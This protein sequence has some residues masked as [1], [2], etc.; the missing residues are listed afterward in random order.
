[1]NTPLH[2]LHATPL[3]IGLVL[4]DSL[5]L[6][7]GVPQHVLIL[8][9]W[10]RGKGHQVHFLTTSTVRSDIPNI[11]SLSAGVV[12][13]DK[14]VLKREEVEI[15]RVKP[16]SKA[17]IK[18]LFS[19]VQFD[20]LHVQM[21]YSPLTSGRIVAAAPAHT[22]IFGT[23]HALPWDPT[24]AT[25]ARLQSWFLRKQIR[26]FQQVFAVSS[27]SANFAEQTLRITP[28]VIGNPVRVL[29]FEQAHDQEIARQAT[30][31]FD[32]D[33]P[34]RIFF[35][36]RI[37]ENKG[38]IPLLAAARRLLDITT[39]PFELVIGG[40]GPL[41]D[42]A[43]TYTAQYGLDSVTTYIGYVP[44]DDKADM[45]AQA[46]ITVL[47][48]VAGE[49]YGVSLV[50]ALAASSGVVVAGD[51][52]GYRPMMSGLEENLIDV[53]NTEAFA[54]ILKKYVEDRD[55]RESVRER[56]VA[57]ARSFDVDTIGTR[58]VQ[59]YLN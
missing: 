5:D 47:P 13:R 43:L 59:A 37:V 55:A 26:R 24:S 18:A 57:R 9:R 6:T 7:D 28:E 33:Q 32:E 29:G 3:T 19:E 41:L 50:E 45:L 20:V 38:I 34:V 42:E 2:D 14:R 27:P 17:K 56:Q 46:D 1:M 39:T 31:N 16:A 4:D 23:Y 53:K 11:H 15:P 22:K 12:R 54:R 25:K 48:A 21:P 35:L 52:P 40:K 8:G 36:G 51:N 58:L 10:L 49:S 30:T 44:E